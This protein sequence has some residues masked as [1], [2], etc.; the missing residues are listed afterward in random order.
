MLLLL[1]LTHSVTGVLRE[2][3]LYLL[4]NCLSWPCHCH[5]ILQHSSADDAISREEGR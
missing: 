5:A 1:L 2:L 4:R 3:L